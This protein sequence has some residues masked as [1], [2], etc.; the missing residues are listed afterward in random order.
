MNAIKTPKTGRYPQRYLSLYLA[1]FRRQLI[2]CRK[3]FC[4]YI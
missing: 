2:I 3:W 4:I 1:Q